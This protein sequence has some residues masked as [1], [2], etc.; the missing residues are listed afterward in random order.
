MVGTLLPRKHLSADALVAVVRSN[1]EDLADPRPGKPTIS[2]A[3]ALMSAFA[4]FALKDPSLLAF[5]QRRNDD[6]LRSLYDIDRV[7]SDTQMRAILDQVPPEKLRPVFQDVFRQVQRGK[8]L[9]PFVYLEGCYVLA[10]DGTGYFSSP[11]IHC[12]SCM[13]KEHA[14]GTVTYYHQMLGAALVHPDKAEVI[15]L[16]PEPIIKQDGQ[17][18]NDCERN[19]ARRFLERFRQE[20]PYLPVIVVE[21][22]LSAN[23]PHLRDLRAARMH[24]ILGV[25]EGDHAYLFE[26]VRQRE[27]DG[28]RVTWVTIQSSDP[29]VRQ[30][31]TIVPDVAVNESNRDLKV[32]FVRYQEMD[33]AQNVVRVFTWI[34]DL[35]VTSANVGKVMRAGRARWKIENETFNTLKNQGYHF[36]HNYGHGEQHLSVVFAMLM[37][38]AFLVDQV[39]QLCDPLFRAVWQ[40]LG[41]KRLLW[42]RVR[43]MFHEYRLRSLRELYEALYYGCIRPRPRFDSS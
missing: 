24:Y 22:A 40:K 8:A 38:L 11:T 33:D 18:K 21:D 31:Y 2:L 5:D 23:A 16:A 29:A 6:N 14:D 4:M 41:S 30:V 39:Q 1:F 32:T 25:K 9:E 17:T 12:S 35:V 28:E 26:E 34:T 36:E 19:A 3:D 10:L 43:G 13:Q 27:E 15:P 37:M 20:H 42:E 7:P